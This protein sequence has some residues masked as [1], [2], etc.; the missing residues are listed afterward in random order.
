MEDEITPRLVSGLRTRAHDGKSKL[1]RY[2]RREHRVLSKAI[3]QHDPSWA[4]I[5]AEVAAANVMGRD[6][7]PASPD[8]VRNIWA[9]VCRDVEVEKAERKAAR[10]KK[11]VQPSRLP[12]TW[13]PTPVPS[14]RAADPARYAPPLPTPARSAPRELT[15][16]A[17]ATLAE[18]DR[19]IAHRDRFVSPPKRKD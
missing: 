6:G 12:A 14:P 13:K 3:A 19:Q 17:K 11:G 10:A 16:E 5:A 2:L 9:R 7:K 15:E 18:L 8:A 1:Y 4:S